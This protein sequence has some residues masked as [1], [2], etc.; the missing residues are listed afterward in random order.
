MDVVG[1]KYTTDPMYRSYSKL[2]AVCCR[3]QLSAEDGSRQV[4]RH[5][6]RAA[7]AR[8]RRTV[9]RLSSRRVLQSG[10]QAIY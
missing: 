7:A 1:R 9:A 2:T 8:S 4:L 10:S 5:L 6:Q 3:L